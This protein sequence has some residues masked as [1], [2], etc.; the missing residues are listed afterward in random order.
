MRHT[1]RQT[2]G[3]PGSYERKK[4]ASCSC[5][6]LCV[7]LV[8][9]SAIQR[10]C[11]VAYDHI[12]LARVRFQLRACIVVD[13]LQPGRLKSRLVLLQVGMAEVAHHLH[14]QAVAGA[15]RDAEMNVK[16]CTSS[17]ERD[18]AAAVGARTVTI[19]ASPAASR[20]EP[21]CVVHHLRYMQAHTDVATVTTFACK[22]C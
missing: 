20:I 11:Q 6:H 10:V 12:K 2:P 5:H 22:M 7:Q 13:Q 16:Q 8:A 3:D 17:E 18:S 4:N 19:C 9:G 14:M 1:P 21:H 15:G